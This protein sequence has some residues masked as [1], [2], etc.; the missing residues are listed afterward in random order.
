MAKQSGI[1]AKLQVDDAG[2]TLR[3]IS[4]N[5]T[6]INLTTPRGVFDVTGLDK[7]GIER[8]LG[9]ADGNVALTGAFD[10]ATNKQHDVFKTVPTT[11]V[12]R[13]VTYD[14]SGI[15]TGAP[16][17]TMEMLFSNYD[18]ARSQDGNLVWTATGQLAN[19]TAPTWITVP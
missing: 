17:L 8:L 12:Q 18:L 13:T 14:P 2:G 15:G 16:R 9:L 4:D 11:S 3:D 7:S 6:S 1:P 19:G 10:P 5:V